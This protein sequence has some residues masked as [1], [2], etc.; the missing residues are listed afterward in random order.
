MYNS[1]FGLV[2]S[3]LAHN[4]TESKIIT[5]PSL[6]LIV[7]STFSEPAKVWSSVTWS[8]Q[9]S[10]TNLYIYSIEYL[11]DGLVGIGSGD[12]KLYVWNVTTAVTWK[13]FSTDP[14]AK[15]LKLIEAGSFLAA[16]MGNGWVNVYNFTN[17]TIYTRFMHCSAD[18]YS[19]ELINKTLLA[20]GCY[21]GSIKVWKWQTGV[22]LFNLTGHTV[23]VNV[24]KLVAINILAS[25]SIDNTIKLWDIANGALLKT[26]IGHSN[27]IV[28][29]DL[30]E[31]CVLISSSIDM[32]I[33]KWDLMN[34]GN[35]INSFNTSSNIQSM[36]VVSPANGKNFSY[37][38]PY[39]CFTATLK[40]ILFQKSVQK[41]KNHNS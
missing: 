12:L 33:K 9:R 4:K 18:I 30:I 26:L 25:S 7:S 27:K 24:L 13:S 16:G 34:G 36:V 6:N 1:S 29:L 8:L 10:Y 22:A 21:D 19:L 40:L 11:G 20:S 15:C 5:I 17:G 35:L 23:N 37:N 31:S 41:K 2:N 28:G 3:F 14:V 38:N 39:L 32:S